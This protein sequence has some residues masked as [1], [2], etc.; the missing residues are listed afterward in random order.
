[1]NKKTLLGTILV[2]SF[3]SAVPAYCGGI[4]VRFKMESFQ[5]KGNDEFKITMTYL[6]RGAL[7]AGI[8]GGL[9]S[10]KKG[11]KVIFHLRHSKRED[12][13]Q[14]KKLMHVSKEEYL[15]CINKV[16]GY[17]QNGKEFIISV[18]SDKYKKIP[19]KENEFQSEQL[20]MGRGGIVTI[21]R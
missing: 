7:Q 11:D 2:I 16:L 1:M 10:V 19:G 9:A 14:G 3:L 15:E 20:F 18:G 12:D 17:Y 21:L 5:A 13:E 4:P 6:G 8:P